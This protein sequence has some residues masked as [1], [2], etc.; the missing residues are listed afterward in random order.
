[1]PVV[2][3]DSADVSRFENATIPVSKIDQVAKADKKTIGPIRTRHMFRDVEYEPYDPVR[4]YFSI[5][6][7]KKLKFFS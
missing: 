6:K 2:A 7:T 4:I 3:L 1:M 5:R